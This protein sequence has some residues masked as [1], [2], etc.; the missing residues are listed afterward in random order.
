[1]SFEDVRNALLVAYGDGFLD[2]EE[3]LFLY[4]YYESVNPSYPYWDFD[5]FF[6]IHLIRASV[7]PTLEWPK[8][9][10]RFY[11][12]P[13]SFRQLSNAHKEQCVAEWKGFA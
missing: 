4:D 10:F 11:W 9:T 1:M 8:T 13:Y 2:D 7:K 5:T 3:F 12:M 6:W